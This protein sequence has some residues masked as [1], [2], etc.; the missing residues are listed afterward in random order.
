M[1]PLLRV[2]R[3]GEPK[4]IPLIGPAPVVKHQQTLR[5]SGSGTL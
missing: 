2:K 5:L 1:Q 4:Q 3:I